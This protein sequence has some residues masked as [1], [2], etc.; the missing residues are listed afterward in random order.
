MKKI[1]S[2]HNTVYGNS[3][4]AWKKIPARR[5]FTLI[6]LLVLVSIIAILAS[7]L[8][9]ALGMARSKAQAAK[10]LNNCRQM[11]LAFVGYN[12][13][14]DYYPGS[15]IG[16]SV[17]HGITYKDGYI[18]WAQLL[19]LQGYLPKSCVGNKNASGNRYATLGILECPEYYRG[20]NAFLS[21][22]AG[23][24]AMFSNGYY[25]AY[26]YNACMSN[27]NTTNDER[28]FGVGRFSTTNTKVGRKLS[29]VTYPSSTMVVADGDYSEYSS[30]GSDLEKRFAKRHN[31]RM[32]LLLGDGHAEEAS[33]I[34]K[35]FY[36][37]YCGVPRR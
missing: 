2:H 5:N 23:V 20:K 32:N 26:V 28:Y 12:N 14:T 16:T 24:Y 22:K 29:Q 33:Y 36:L 21:E 15:H 11:G 37:L 8:L 6:E 4:I 34:I 10:C 17:W 7:L 27:G 30:I 13:D 9:P 25:A 19:Y 31:R 18:N 1:H 3:T 35:T